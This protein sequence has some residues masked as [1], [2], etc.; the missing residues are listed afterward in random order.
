MTVTDMPTTVE[1]QTTEQ[2][3]A[4]WIGSDAVAAIRAIQA[5]AV[6]RGT[7]NVRPTLGQVELSEADGK[8]RVVATDTYCMAIVPMDYHGE[9]TVLPV[10]VVTM[11]SKIPAAELKRAKTYDPSYHLTITR[12]GDTVT[13]VVGGS[14][15]TRTASDRISGPYPRWEM[16]V[17]TE[18]TISTNPVGFNPTFL[19]RTARWAKMFDDDTAPLVLVN[20]HDHKP[21]VWQFRSREHG[22]LTWLQ[23][24]IRLG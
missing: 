2:L 20:L 10:G 9:T 24:G 1:P 6:T 13:A 15:G 21:T 8:G 16:L 11:I 19:A 23:M 18:Y 17:P 12:F 5:A 22:V 4:S 14:D 3:V 7:D